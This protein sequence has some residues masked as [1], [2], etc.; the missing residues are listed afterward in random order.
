MTGVQTCALPIFNYL[1]GLEWT[2]NYYIEGCIDWRWCYNY[3]YAP[4]FK[5][6]LKYIPYFETR[7]LKDK[8]KKPIKELVQLCYVLSLNQLHILPNDIDIKLKKDF[9]DYYPEN[10]EFKW[11]FCRYFW[12]SHPNL[13]DIPL[14]IMEKWE[15]M[16][17]NK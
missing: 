4:L 1:E 14:N 10:V 12:E 11:A 15:K 2:F 5:D 7:F 8:G 13:P 3:H 17:G 16:W 6:L 9:T